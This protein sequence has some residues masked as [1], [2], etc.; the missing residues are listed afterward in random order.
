MK[1]T[2]SISILV[3]ISWVQTFGY[4]L[5]ASEQPPLPIYR[6]KLTLIDQMYF[7]LPTIKLSNEV[8]LHDSAIPLYLQLDL[9]YTI[10][11]N[12]EEVKARG[13]YLGTRCNGY[14]RRTDYGSR[15]LSFG[16]FYQKSCLNDYLKVT[17]EVPGL[18]EYHEYK[19]M[20]FYKERFGL[21]IEMIQQIELQ[22]GFFIEFTAGLGV[23]HMRTITPE[24]VTQKTFVNG[25]LYGKDIIEPSC[26][27]S[28]KI[29]KT[30][31]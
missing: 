23:V 8:L 28:M 19:K 17:T 15:G 18:G 16:G 1:K 22:K 9:G 30:I 6:L 7:S 4:A 20:K 13:W 2:I 11:S 14:F 3:F 24:I 29:G 10:Y 27:I 12:D 31:L 21:S 5:P 26:L 25:L